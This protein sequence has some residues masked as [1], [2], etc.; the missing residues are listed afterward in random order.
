MDPL[1][2]LPAT[3]RPSLALRLA[4][5]FA[6]ILAAAVALA[7]GHLIAGLIAPAASPVLA[8]GSAMVDLAPQPLKAFAIETFGE[9]DKDALLAGIGVA[10]VAIAALLG[11]LTRTRP[12]LGAAAILVFG[13]L[14]AAAATARPISTVAWVLPALIGALAGAVVILL[15]LRALATAIEA[16]DRPAEPGRLADPGPA[17]GRLADP[18]P[19]A[20]GARR[21]F[22][23]G[24]TAAG[25]LVFLSGGLGVLLGRSRAADVG[26]VVLPTP[27][28]AAPAL[29]AGATLDVEGV[30]SFYTP[31]ADFYRVDTALEIPVIDADTWTLRIHGMV[32][33]EVT[34]TLPELLE[35]PTIE[36]DITLACVS[37]QVGGPYVG[38]ARWIG[39]PLAVVLELAGV[40]PGADQIVS[41]SIDG[42]TIGTPTAIA[43]DGR[44]A[45]LA[46]GMNGVPLPPVN[47]YPVRMLVP[48]LYGY[49]SATK[50]LVEL[51]LTTFDAYDPYWVQRGWAP[52]APIKTMSRIDTPKPLSTVPGGPSV[53]GGV[54]WAQH[55]GIERVE[56]RIDDGVW[57][58]ATLARF[59]DIDTWRQWTLPWDA[60]PGRHRLEVRAT[61][62]DGIIQTDV[63]REPFPDGATGWHSVVMTVE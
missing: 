60:T 58:A 39:V 46:V 23:L 48:G 24:A 36:R 57:Q 19:A 12:V 10:V 50:W 7:V 47:G 37:N 55:R 43:L 13:L 11:L 22:L 8:V 35:L 52:E 54:A 20:D 2:H 16:R 38:N 9:R 32:D 27:V 26:S 15:L 49:V 6:G 17:D 51:E 31:N 34:L 62:G 63:R 14:G 5:A 1:P 41:R 25:A 56:V 30:S 21:G 28:D 18:G 61:D 45:M 40:M 53:I 42:M 44:D 29:P 33:R 59:D 3:S 4:A